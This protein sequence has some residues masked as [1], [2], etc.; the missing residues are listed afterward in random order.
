MLTDF[1]SLTEKVLLI[2]NISWQGGVC[3]SDKELDY[4][5]NSLEMQIRD[6]QTDNCNL[7]NRVYRLKR[8]TSYLSAFTFIFAILFA[9]LIVYII[10]NYEVLKIVNTLSNF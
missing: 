8:I 1:Y 3:M 4:V 10:N 6:L 2:Y 7:E 9:I 5:L